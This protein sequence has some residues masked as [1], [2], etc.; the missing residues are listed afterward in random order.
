MSPGLL[1]VFGRRAINIPPSGVLM[2]TYLLLIAVGT[3][4]L[5]LPAATHGGISWSDAVFTATS[6]VTV[7]GLVVVETGGDFTLLARP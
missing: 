3:M 4:L 5:M 7:T 2:L 6:A 1:S